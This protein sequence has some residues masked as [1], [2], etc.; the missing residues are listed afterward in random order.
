V[1]DDV[2][3]EEEIALV[4]PYSRTGGRTRS[5]FDLAIEALVSTTERAEITVVDAEHQPIVDLCRQVRSVAEVA[6]L[7]HIPLGV[8]RILV[9]DMAEL[10]L[11]SVHRTLPGTPPIGIL[12]RVLAGLRRL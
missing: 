1:I 3:D 4:R 5:V 11:V 8:A 6:A 12:E 10:G 7:L 9:A 2:D